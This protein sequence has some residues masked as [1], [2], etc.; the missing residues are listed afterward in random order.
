M[1][2][3]KTATIAPVTE[4]IYANTFSNTQGVYAKGHF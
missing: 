3:A 1:Q 2:R 4:F